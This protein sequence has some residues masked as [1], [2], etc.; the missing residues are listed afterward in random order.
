MCRRPLVIAVDGPGGAGKT[1]AS[2]RLADELGVPYLSTGVMYRAVGLAVLNAGLDLE[3]EAGISSFLQTLEM[4]VTLQGSEPIVRINGIAQGA[5]LRT[6]EAAEMASHVAT[7]P[8]VRRF[9]VAQQRQIAESTGGVIEGR[10]IGTRVL[11]QA[12]YKFYLDASLEVR[13]RR[14]GE[15]LSAVGRQV[16]HDV[17]LQ[18]LANRDHK[19]RTRS[20]SPLTYDESYTYLDTSSM[21]LGQVVAAM[22]SHV[23]AGDPACCA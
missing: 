20:D 12:P 22:L 3:D 19:D 14:R 13:A 8:A 1:S 10:D 11:P 6:P 21:T 15:E 5:E 4:Q 16:D 7:M 9:L 23:Q 18:Q 17:L 2:R